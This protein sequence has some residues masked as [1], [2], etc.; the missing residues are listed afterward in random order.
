MG[1]A[2]NWKRD[3]YQEWEIMTCWLPAGHKEPHEGSV[4]IV[5]SLINTITEENIYA[6]G[7]ELNPPKP[8]YTDN[9]PQV[10]VAAS[11]VISP[12]KLPSETTQ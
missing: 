5:Y 11:E 6:P 10:E 12:E 2:I 7:Q 9:M 1:L 3:I 4:E 8:H